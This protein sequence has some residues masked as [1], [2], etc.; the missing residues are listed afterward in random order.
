M[1]VYFSLC[2]RNGKTLSMT[3]WGYA[4]VDICVH[5]TKRV[6][7]HTRSIVIFEFELTN[8]DFGGLY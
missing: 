2:A 7:L 4:E 6:C 5:S 8:C 3:S 1:R